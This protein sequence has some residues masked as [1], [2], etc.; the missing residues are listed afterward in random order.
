M[1]VIIADIHGNYPALQA[2]LEDIRKYDVT[3]IISLGDVAGYYCMINECIE[4][5]A[6][7]GI[8]NILGNHDWY[9]VNDEECPR[10]RSANTCLEYQQKVILPENKRWLQK[11]CNSIQNESDLMIHGGVNNFLDEYLYSI[12]ENYGELFKQQN[13]F[14]GH[15]HVQKMITLENGK[16]IINPGS[17]GQP[18]DGDPRASYAIKSE[19]DIILNRVDY[20]IDEAAS[21]MRKAGFDE[22]YYENLYHGTRIGGKIDQITIQKNIDYENR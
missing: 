10:S 11:S 21:T 3:D 15:T 17:V 9:I 13:L 1:I 18:R 12:P 8:R 20:D 16:R 4:T 7:N 6:T 5:L 22:Y 19:D 14:I 2:V